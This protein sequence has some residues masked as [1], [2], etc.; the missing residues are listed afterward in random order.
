MLGDIDVR[1]SDCYVAQDK[2]NIFQVVEASVG[3]AA[4]NSMVAGKMR[5]WTSSAVDTSIARSGA[6]A[7][8]LRTQVWDRLMAKGSIFTAGA[9]VS[10]TLVRLSCRGAC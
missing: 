4:L 3:C 6:D 2:A 9:W 5:D 7:D 1:K 10:T 8:T